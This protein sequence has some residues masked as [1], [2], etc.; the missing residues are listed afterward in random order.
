MNLTKEPPWYVI[1]MPGGV[2]GEGLR[3]LSLSRLYVSNDR[4]TVRE[5]GLRESLSESL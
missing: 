3:G 5:Y 2:G 4:E 1:R